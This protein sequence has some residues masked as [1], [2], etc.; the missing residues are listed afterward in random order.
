MKTASSV[1]PRQQDILYLLYLWRFLSSSQIQTLL[2]H[3][4]KHRIN[5]WLRDLK[6]KQYIHGRY[7]KTVGNINKPAVYYSSLGAIAYLKTRSDTATSVI[8][9]LYR[10]NKVSQDFIDRK[11]LVADIAV[12][13]A[14][15]IK[16]PHEI[17]T[18]SHIK[19][20]N[21]KAH[22]LSEL[23]LIPDLI[24]IRQTRHGVRANLLDFL[25]PEKMKSRL[26]RYLELYDSRDWEDH[27]NMKFPGLMFICPDTRQLLH[28]KRYLRHLDPDNEAPFD[29][30]TQSDIKDRGIAI[31][32]GLDPK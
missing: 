27:M 18:P 19:N 3:K 13:L 12:G 26:I 25:T 7:D 32:L 23:D 4:D 6:Q 2:G 1:T 22:F 14:G 31:R 21:S 9:R 20:P 17:G 8:Q 24:I 11:L 28:A 15:T 30:M 10:D 5:L 16:N 29:F